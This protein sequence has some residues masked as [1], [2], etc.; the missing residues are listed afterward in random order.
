MTREELIQSYLNNRL[1]ENEKAEFRHLLQTDPEFEKE[2]SFQQDLKVAFSKMK[3][4]AMKEKL[5]SI[6]D[7]L[8]PARR[9]AYTYWL[10]AASILIIVGI[11]FSLIFNNSGSSEKL[12]L[13][14][15]EPYEN[16]VHPVTRGQE[17]ETLEAAVFQEYENGNYE[18]AVDGF[19]KLYENTKHGYYLLYEANAMMA[20]GKVENAV[21]ILKEHLALHDV[22]GEKSR[23]YLALAFL[24]TNE[25]AKA[26]ELFQEIVAAKSFRAEQAEAILEELK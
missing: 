26:K 17:N 25:T 14:Y 10:A 20:Q 24:E 11:A 19:K 22:F 8:R 9:N 23:W 2:V 6:E 3:A 13:A 15:F 12:Y 7:D 4:E 5:K 21:P 1:N 18:K 16:V